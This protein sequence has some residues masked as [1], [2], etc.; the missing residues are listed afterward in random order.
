M[1]HHNKLR[2]VQ[3]RMLLPFLGALC[4]SPDSSIPSHND[5]LQ[6]TNV[7]TSRELCTR[8]DYCGLERFPAWRSQDTEHNYIMEIEERGMAWVGGE[9]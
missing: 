2:T 4:G 5:V 9:G 1:A 3:H 6:Q 7:I 8:E